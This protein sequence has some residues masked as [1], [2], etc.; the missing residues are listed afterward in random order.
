[1]TQTTH[2]RGRAWF[3]AAVL[4]A[5][6]GCQN[7]EDAK[8]EDE[9][10]E[11]V[12]PTPVEVA[13]VSRGDISAVYT[14]TATL[15]A[16]GEALVMAK[17]GGLIETLLVNEGDVVAANQPIAR[18]EDDRL[19]LEVKR[20]RANLERTAQEYKRNVELHEKGLLPAGTFEGLKYDLD[21]L[22]AAYELAELELNNATVRAPIAGV[23]SERLVKA[24]NTITAN[25]GIF[26]IT[27]LD[28]LL[29]YLYVPEREF[30]KLKADQPV[31]MAVD[32]L[33]GQYFEGRI[34][35]ISP[36]IDAATATFKVTAEINDESG[37][38]KPG[39]FGRVNVVYDTRRG[40]ALVP[41]VALLDNESDTSVF[42]IEDGIANRRDVSVGYSDGGSMEVIAGLQPGDQVVVIGQN[43]L[44]QD[45]MV[46]VIPPGE[47]V[48]KIKPKKKDEG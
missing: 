36:V 41:R 7:G 8:S 47:S 2:N 1:M 9:T 33:P 10:E 39:M 42:V 44:K 34:Q 21:A 20:A 30:R 28:P 29:A 24:G 46:H 25:V 40:V 37:Q 48:A 31:Q 5:V 27:D 3:L 43:G 35:L 12:L 15:E 16:D 17:V 13:L 19:K 38:L 14:G 18:I 32:A 22:K 45:A 11:E 4:L 23:I 6:A 26:R